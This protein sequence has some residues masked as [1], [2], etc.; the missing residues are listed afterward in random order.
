MAC[1]KTSN[2]RLSQTT[3]QAAISLL[4]CGGEAPD[5]SKLGL[6]GRSPGRDTPASGKAAGCG[7]SGGG[8]PGWEPPDGCGEGS[9]GRSPQDSAPGSSSTPESETRRHSG[10]S[11]GGPGSRV[12]PPGRGRKRAPR[13]SGRPSQPSPEGLGC[14]EGAASPA[15]SFQL[16]TLFHVRAQPPARRPARAL[17]PPFPSRAL[18]LVPS[19]DA[20]PRS[21][22][23][24]A[25][26]PARSP[27]LALH[28]WRGRAG[29]RAGGDREEG[30]LPQPQL[31]SPA[32]RRAPKAGV[33]APLP[34]AFCSRAAR[35]GAPPAE[36]AAVSPRRPRR[37]RA[38]RSPRSPRSAGSPAL[39]S[40]GPPAA[41]A[42]KS[43]HFPRRTSPARPPRGSPPRRRRRRRFPGCGWCPARQSKALR[44]SGETRGSE[45]RP[46]GGQPLPGQPSRQADEA[47]R[48]GGGCPG[49]RRKGAGRTRALLRLRRPPKGPG[50]GRQP[51]EPAAPTLS[52]PGPEKPAPTVVFTDPLVPAR[53]LLLRVHTARHVSPVA[54]GD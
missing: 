33:Q 35:P 43:W 9:S 15:P 5:P 41:G 1:A 25:R 2:Q 50:P 17:Q 21:H 49:P 37:E 48:E 54:R 4:R 26:R 45:V 18:L 53:V 11:G 19:G 24:R 51:R 27:V 47:Q 30:P 20:S 38:P 16:T 52:S 13:L 44:P 36:T 42:L 34:A 14:S 7:S 28:P 12:R 23:P 40:R 39:P 32:V 31:G 22:P 29:L 6:K 46:R 3:K 8:R 10:P